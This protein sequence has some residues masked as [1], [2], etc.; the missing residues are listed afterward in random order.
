LVFVLRLAFVQ[1]NVFQQEHS[2]PSA[3]SF[4]IP[5]NKNTPSFSHLPSILLPTRTLHPFRTF[6][7]ESLQQEHSIL[8]APFFE[9]P[10]KQE[11]SILSAPSFEIPSNKN[12]ASLPRLP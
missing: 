4:E 2:V 7:R 12:T 10:S 6:L 5:T 8:S 11:H 3:P 1:E 9:I